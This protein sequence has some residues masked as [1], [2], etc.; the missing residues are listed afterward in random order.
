M[1]GTVALTPTQLYTLHERHAVCTLIKLA[2]P[3]HSVS[4]HTCIW[5]AELIH[6][7]EGQCTHVLNHSG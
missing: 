2:V 3:I 1:T 6:A 4:G 5:V 7:K